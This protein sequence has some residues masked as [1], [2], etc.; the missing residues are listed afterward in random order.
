MQPHFFEETKRYLESLGYRHNIKAIAFTLIHNWSDHAST[1]VAAHMALYTM[2]KDIKK[3][4]SSIR[5]TAM[6]AFVEH[7]L[8]FPIFFQ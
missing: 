6:F 4:R 3:R 7:H 2:A 1:D 8:R 5:I